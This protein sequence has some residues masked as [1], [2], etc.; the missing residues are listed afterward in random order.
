VLCVVL[1][2]MGA[3]AAINPVPSTAALQP[4]GQK[5][6]YTSVGLLANDSVILVTSD[7]MTS[8]PAYNATLFAYSSATLTLLNSVE[9]AHC[10]SLLV[11]EVLICD[12]Q[13]SGTGPTVLYR[14]QAD[15]TTGVRIVD[16]ITVPL[17]GRL[18]TV[19][20]VHVAGHGLV[21]VQFG[22]ATRS[23][24]RSRSHSKGMDS[25]DFV[26]WELRLK[27][28]DYKH[29]RAHSRG[30]GRAG[31]SS[32]LSSSGSMELVNIGSLGT[33]GTVGPDILSI[34][35]PADGSR[36]FVSSASF[37][38]YSYPSLELL[39]NN[40]ALG[41]TYALISADTANLGL[42]ITNAQFTMGLDYQNY[43]FDANAPTSGELNDNSTGF[44]SS[45]LAM[46]SLVSPVGPCVYVAGYSSSQHS[47]GL[48]SQ[49]RVPTAPS[50][51]AVIQS[52]VPIPGNP[53]GTLAANQDY[54]F[55]VY[56]QTL[57][58]YQA[59]C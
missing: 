16:Q 51:G 12:Y 57:Y 23:R 20:P 25:I 18:H 39:N 34:T 56:Q 49:V 55:V 45:G 58:R 13:S 32:S 5:F 54:V 35:M 7:P 1:M 14:L 2:K 40:T 17:E 11:G 38:T 27:D 31:R 46:T 33:D 24:S 8:D 28:R 53:L 4:M 41:F 26:V 3:D 21:M 42:Q 44:F 48:L 29:G 50:D 6:Y 43:D 15:A 30:S 59:T 36:L 37:L 52:Q 47:Y 9:L 22:D 10:A 19:A